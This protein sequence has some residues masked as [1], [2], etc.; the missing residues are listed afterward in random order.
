VQE[1]N[2]RLKSDL[3]RVR[4]ELTALRGNV[5]D[6]DVGASSDATRALW[7]YLIHR[8]AVSDFQ[9]ESKKCSLRLLSTGGWGYRREQPAESGG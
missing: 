8:A 3:Y 9:T 2:Q 6:D 7:C 5:T 1:E 4:S